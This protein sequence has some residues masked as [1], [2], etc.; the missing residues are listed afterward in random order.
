MKT[1]KQEHKKRTGRT[2]SPILQ[3]KGLNS[4]YGQVQILH[5]VH[6]QV[7]PREMVCIIGP[8]GAGKST[9]LKNVFG[10]IA[11]NQGEILFEEKSI[12]KMAPE[13]I[14]RHG[15]SI[16]PQ[17]RSV[18]P[19]LTVRENLELGAYIRSGSEAIEQD[20]KKIF[21]KERQHQKAG[22][23][24]GGE[25]QMVA[26]GRALMIKPKLLLLDEPSLGLSPKMKQVIFEKIVEINRKEGIAV[27]VV[28]QNARLS[29]ALSDYAYV[30]ELGRNRLE[31]DANKLL[32]DKRVAKLYL[33]GA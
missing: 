21:E 32:R 6:L 2:G 33:G 23:L 14:V 30:L 7:H 8:N 15:I 18:F 19:R 3:I 9:I 11:K 25:Q 17:G 29:L 1:T 5:D 24:S 13:K 28:E 10:L 12:R 16:V 26:I 22:L 20:I 31:G 27:L 4:W